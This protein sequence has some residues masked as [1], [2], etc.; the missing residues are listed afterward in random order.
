MPLGG[1]ED[2]VE[3]GE[4]GGEEVL[5]RLDSTL[6]VREERAFEVDS[7]REGANLRILIGMFAFPHF[8][9][10]RQPV[11]C[12]QSRF[13]RSG[14]SSRK[15]TRDPVPRQ[16]L[17][18]R[19]QRLGGIVHDVVSGAAVNVKI[20]VTRRHNAIAKIAH[21]NSGG[22]LPAAWS[23]NFEDASLLDEHERMLDGIRWSQQS[24]SSKS[25]H[26]NV[27]IAEKRRL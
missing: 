6:E 19:R 18:D 27:L 3:E 22:K 8:D 24:S 23:G 17:F 13:H 20:N 16:Q 9:R 5:G 2:A 14:D 26:R 15:I 4:V 1:F 25:H 12:A 10:I 21:R 11:E 7:E